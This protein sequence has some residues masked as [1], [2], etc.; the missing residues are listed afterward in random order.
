MQKEDYI[1]LIKK[2]GFEIKILNEDKDIS[3]R[4]YNG[5]K[6]ESIKIEASKNQ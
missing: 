5:I 6:L 2:A 1:S 4:Q 3:K